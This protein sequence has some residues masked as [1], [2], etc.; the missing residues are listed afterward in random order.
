MDS[1]SDPKRYMPDEARLATIRTH[2][3]V[4]NA[5]RP[6]ILK[7]AHTQVALYMGGYV[8]AA[9]LILLTT[10]HVDEKHKVVGIVLGLAIIGGVKVWEYAWKPVTD[11]QL[12]LRY[13]LFPVIF[14]FIDNVQYSH[15]Q[16]PGFLQDINRMKL[17]RFTKSENDDVISGRHDGLDFEM[18]E[19]KLNA[20]SGKSK[21]VVF[22][23]LIFRFNLDTEFRGT[24][25]AAKRG[26]WLDQFIR[27]IFGM[28]S[29]MIAS[30]DFH[31]DQSH[32]FHTD[33]YSDARPL[34]EGPLAA[35][36]KYLKREWWAGE[37]RIALRGKECFL[38]LP[39]DRDYFAL[40]DI[41]VNVDYE[42]DIEPMIRD[43]AVLLA[44]AHLLR[45]V[46]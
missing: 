19:A 16:E 38:L 17:V 2:I 9:G 22:S 45:K 24:L 3:A 11:H 43:M 28:D 14:G 32:E 29:D 33:N 23:G 13:R 21:T 40:P 26:N 10:L 46:G 20:G 7:H 39:S 36:M 8:V 27:D 15:G 41:N 1:L 12:T 34:V 18:V 35:A 31:L 25:V 30:G 4:Y 42:A 6:A 5:E 44:V 37:V